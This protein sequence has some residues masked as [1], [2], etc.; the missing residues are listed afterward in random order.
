MFKFRLDS[1]KAVEA[2]VIL[3]RQSPRRMISRKRLLALLYIANRECL[4]RSGRPIIGGRLVAMKYGPIHG[5]VYDLINKRE[6]TE[7]GEEWSE[8]FHND[9]YFVVLHDE[10]T[11]SALSRFEIGILNEVLERHEEEDDWD[12]TRYTHAFP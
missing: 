8:H 1:K 10:P 2:A 11:I 6:G 5:D 9:R 3:A 12:V 7:G 4:K